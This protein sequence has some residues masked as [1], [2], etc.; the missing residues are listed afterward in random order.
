[1]N[2]RGTGAIFC[3]IA[4]LLLSARYITE[5]IFMSN[6]ASWDNALFAASL[7]YQGNGLLIC[8]VISFVLG[9]IYLIWGEVEDRSKHK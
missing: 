3:L 7:E 9:A 6:V 8:S 1:M 2:K 4:G 5:A